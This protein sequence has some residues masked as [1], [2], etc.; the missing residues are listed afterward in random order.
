MASKLNEKEKGEGVFTG[1]HFP[2]VLNVHTLE[3][4][5]WDSANKL[6]WRRMGEWRYGSRILS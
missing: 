6:L 4:L 3:L 1:F 2:D 5:N